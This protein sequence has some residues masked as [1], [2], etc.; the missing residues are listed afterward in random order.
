MPSQN[1]QRSILPPIEHRKVNQPTH[2]E[3]FNGCS[4]YKPRRNQAKIMDKERMACDKP[5]S[6]SHVEL[7]SGCINKG[8]IF[9]H[10]I[11]DC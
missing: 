6:Q 1:T 11:I 10:K 5:T 4:P 8:G 7:F 3:Q 9:T 2:H